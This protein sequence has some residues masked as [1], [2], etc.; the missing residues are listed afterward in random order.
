MLK[1]LLKEGRS[2]DIKK[3]LKYKAL[4]GTKEV[5]TVISKGKGQ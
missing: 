2:G 5:L 1:G 4:K 3:K